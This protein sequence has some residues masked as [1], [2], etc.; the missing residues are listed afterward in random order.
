[1]QISAGLATVMDGTNRV[2]GNA[3][4]DWSEVRAGWSVFSVLPEPGHNVVVV[5]TKTAPGA[6][7]SGFWELTLSANWDQGDAINAEYRI[8]KDFTPNKNFPLFT[9]G[10]F[11]VTQILN[12]YFLMQDAEPPAAAAGLP[13][14]GS[15]AELDAMTTLDKTKPSSYF[16]TESGVGQI[17]RLLAGAPTAGTSDRPTSDD[18]TSHFTQTL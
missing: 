2:I 6:T 1:M 12:R 9:F 10:D 18:A 17:W 3:D 11:F 5:Q 14:L 8:H 4:T 16:L 7:V 13:E 15:L